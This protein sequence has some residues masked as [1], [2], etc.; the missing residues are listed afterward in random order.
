[1]A[2]ILTSGPLFRGDPT[3]S[4]RKIVRGVLEAQGSV[5][6]AVAKQKTPVG[7]SGSAKGA[8]KRTTVSDLEVRVSGGPTAGYIETGTRPHWAPPGSLNLWIQRFLGV[9]NMQDMITGGGRRLIGQ[10]R[11][12]AMKSRK[13]SEKQAAMVQAR[14]VAG[15]GGRT[16]V[17]GIK[18]LDFLIRRAISRR[19]TALSAEMRSVDQLGQSPGAAGYWPFTAAKNEINQQQ[20]LY[21]ADL[22]RKIAQTLGGGS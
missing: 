12:R 3:G 16:I 22:A 20:G 4:V 6:E 9:S 13:L 18:T 10:G 17:Y 1:M 15:G 5:V 11:G 19:G 2:P 14:G 21:Q 7:V 8:I